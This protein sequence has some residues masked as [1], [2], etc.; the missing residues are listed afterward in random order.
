[1]IQFFDYERKVKADE[2]PRAFSEFPHVRLSKF[3]IVDEVLQPA[4]ILFA[5]PNIIRF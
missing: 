5:W 4:K 3:N 1:M 2:Y